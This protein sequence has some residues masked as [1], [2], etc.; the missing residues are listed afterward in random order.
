MIESPEGIWINVLSHPQPIFN[1]NGKMT[2]AINMLV[3]IS[4]KKSGEQA[5]RESEN[6]YKTVKRIVGEI[7]RR[8]D[9]DFK[10]E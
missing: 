6:K 3:D 4:E 9:A 8:K 10:R 7:N 5:I 1:G 2:G